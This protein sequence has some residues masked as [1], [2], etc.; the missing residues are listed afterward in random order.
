MEI[1]WT[2][3]LPYL[4]YRG[5]RWCLDRYWI[6]SSGSVFANGPRRSRYSHHYG[7]QMSPETVTLETVDGRLT[8]SPTE[9]Q[10]LGALLEETDLPGGTDL[11]TQ[12]IAREE[13][14]LDGLPDHAEYLCLSGVSADRLP[15]VDVLA[16]C[17]AAVS[18]ETVIAARY[19]IGVNWKWQ[20]TPGPCR[21]Q[22]PVIM[23][24]GSQNPD[25]YF[26]C[27]I[28][29]QDIWCRSEGK[30]IWNTN[31]QYLVTHTGCCYQAGEDGLWHKYRG[32]APAD[33]P[34]LALD[35]G[36]RGLTY[37]TPPPIWIG[38]CPPPEGAV[39]RLVATTPPVTIWVRAGPKGAHTSQPRS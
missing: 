25:Q 18:A 8:L 22:A 19:Y 13:S 15:S 37:T 9:C 7:I 39:Y 33:L 20:T 1:A 38:T 4:H 2:D 36:Y 16:L 12:V 32:P 3:G 29:V 14:D 5:E 21:L 35:Y 6:Q 10:E 30:R 27:Q 23:I 26:D 24:H 11:G 28:L 17:R 34:G 31:A